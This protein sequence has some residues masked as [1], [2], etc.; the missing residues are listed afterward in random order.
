MNTETALTVEVKI[1]TTISGLLHQAEGLEVVDQE[2]A[3]AAGAIVK[4]LKSE[5]KSWEAYWED[6]K[7]KAKAAHSIL[8]DREGEVTKRVR[9]IIARLSEKASAWFYSER[10]KFRKAKEDRERAEW[11]AKRKIEEA[12][13]K[14][15]ASSGFEAAAAAIAE[16]PQEDLGPAPEAPRVEDAEFRDNWLWEVDNFER[17]PP[18]FL[19]TDKK[20]IEEFIDAKKNKTEES[21][22]NLIDGIRV[23]NKPIMAVKRRSI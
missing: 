8:C 1:K 23:Y 9:P 20:A 10:E 2:S 6:P 18:R 7:A 16:I 21:V 15:E 17:I 12:E 11:E 3:D 13:K 4:G 5:L 22:K 14:V 19:T